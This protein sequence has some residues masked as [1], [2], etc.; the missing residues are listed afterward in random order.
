MSSDPRVSGEAHATQFA[1]TA[2]DY[3]RYRVPYP[4]EVF[5][6]IRREYNLD[7]RGRLLDVGCGTGYACLPLSR[8]FED[9]VI[10]PEPDMLR[11]VERAARSQG[12]GNIRFM[13]QRAEEISPSLAPLRLV[14]FGNS[15]HWT[16]RVS[17]AHT[18]FPLIEPGGGLVALASSRKR[19]ARRCPAR[20]SRATTACESTPMPCPIS[21]AR[22]MTSF[23]PISS[24]GSYR[25]LCAARRSSINA[26]L[27]EPRSRKMSFCP[28]REVIEIVLR[29]AHGWPRAT[30]TTRGS[31]TRGTRTRRGGVEVPPITPRS[32]SRTASRSS[33]CCEFST[34]NWTRSPG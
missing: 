8:W 10:D 29:F 26:R 12:V 13:R 7:G 25:M 9:V 16:D 15:F 28:W 21:T 34:D 33:T 31:F 20:T 4:D 1:G 18:L 23:E 6:W 32:S 3:Q 5:D 14:T 22:L 30:T 19:S 27:A 17:V 11:V 24:S 2:E